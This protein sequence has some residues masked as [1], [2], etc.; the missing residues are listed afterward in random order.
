MKAIHKDS[1]ARYGAPKIH[2]MLLKEGY[3]VSIKRVQ[4]LIKKADIRS[5]TKRKFRPQSNKGKVIEGTNILKQDFS[6]TTINQ[7][8]V[9]DITH[10]Y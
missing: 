9:G 7:K 8:W 4:R 5:I 1:H 10:I 2:Q 6:T 3:K